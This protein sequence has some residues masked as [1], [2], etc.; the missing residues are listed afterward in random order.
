MGGRGWGGVCKEVSGITGA[1][2]YQGT[3]HRDILFHQGLLA[4]VTQGDYKS[5]TG[6][7]VSYVALHTYYVRGSQPSGEFIQV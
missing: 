7:D 5:A 2:P 6:L 3:E 1:T 4:P